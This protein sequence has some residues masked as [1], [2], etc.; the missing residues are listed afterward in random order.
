IGFV[1]LVLWIICAAGF[2]LWV[3]H[4]REAVGAFLEGGG[5]VAMQTLRT[6]PFGLT[7]F[8]SWVLFGIGALFAFIAFV[9]ALSMDDPYPFYGKLDRALEDARAAYA[10][11]RDAL[12]ADLEDI[13]RDTIQAMQIAKDDLVKR[14]G[15]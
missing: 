9:D 10:E 12:I 15:E 14:R 6:D 5:K 11:E 7:D 2:N 4:Y 13:K 3:A 1:S 8:Q